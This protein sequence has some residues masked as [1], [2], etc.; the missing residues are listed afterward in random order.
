M[1]LLELADRCE[2]ATAEQ[3]RELLEAAWAAIH[4]SLPRRNRG[5]HNAENSFVS[6]LDAKAYESAA[7]TLVPEDGF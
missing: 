5:G 2:A 7:M 3:Q 6:M 1:T 4:G